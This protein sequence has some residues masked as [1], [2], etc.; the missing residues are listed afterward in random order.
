[1]EVFV[2]ISLLLAAALQLAGEVTF[3]QLRT[4]Q[5]SI[6]VVYKTKSYF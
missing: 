6:V 1:M 4:I 3:H 5:D 2:T